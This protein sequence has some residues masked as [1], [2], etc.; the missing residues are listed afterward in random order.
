MVEPSRFEWRAALGSWRW[1]ILGAIGAGAACGGKAGSDASSSEPGGQGEGGATSG[2]NPASTGGS[3]MASPLPE[4]G[5]AAGLGG[6]AGGA[7]SS[8]LPPVTQPSVC[9]DQTNLD[10]GLR[11]CSNG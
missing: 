6:M 8:N 3:A 9:K 5:G 4:R 1:L 7:G 2:V 11:S 10:G